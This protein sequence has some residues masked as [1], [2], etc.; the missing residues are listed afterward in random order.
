MPGF[1]TTLV[2]AQGD[3]TAVTGTAEATLLPG[4]A[5]ISIPLSLPR[6]S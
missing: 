1:Q 2:E 5:R 3:G 6:G 4:A